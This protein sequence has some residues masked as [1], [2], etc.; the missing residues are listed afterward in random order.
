MGDKLGAA[1]GSFV[2]I[3]AVGEE[4]GPVL[5]ISVLMVGRLVGD[6]LGIVVGYGDG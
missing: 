6:L 3:V 4:V 2:D 5:G 1:E